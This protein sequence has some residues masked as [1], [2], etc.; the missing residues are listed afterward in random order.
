M[1]IHGHSPPAIYERLLS[2]ALP[3][4]N[5]I[6]IYVYVQVLNE[7]LVDRGTSPYLNSLELEVDGRYV[8]HVQAD[9]LIV[10]TPTGSTAYSMSAGGTSIL[11]AYGHACI[12]DAKSVYVLRWGHYCCGYYDSSRRFSQ[13]HRC[14]HNNCLLCLNVHV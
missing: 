8:T 11:V 13:C 9:G 1:H 6:H 7:L 2:K 4:H 5:Y 12:L 14:N 10:S 3:T